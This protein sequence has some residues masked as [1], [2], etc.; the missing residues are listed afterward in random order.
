M[1]QQDYIQNAPNLKVL[2]LYKDQSALEKTEWIENY[3]GFENG[4]AGKDLY[5]IGIEQAKNLGLM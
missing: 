1:F 3:Y 2:I 4:I 5:K